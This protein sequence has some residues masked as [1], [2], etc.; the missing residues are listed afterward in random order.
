MATCSRLQK[1]PNLPK[2]QGFYGSKDEK[3]AA[4]ETARGLHGVQLTERLTA[5]LG[6][7]NWK[8]AQWLCAALAAPGVLLADEMGP[9]EDGHL[10]SFVSGAHGYRRVECKAHN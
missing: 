2:A 10:F 3:Q 9:R 5:V 8:I 7:T 4:S 6:R 1:V